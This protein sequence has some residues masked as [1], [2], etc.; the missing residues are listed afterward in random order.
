MIPISIGF[1]CETQFMIPVLVNEKKIKTIEGSTDTFIQYQLYSK[2]NDNLY[3]YG[4]AF[5]MTTDFAASR[6]FQLAR[7]TKEIHVKELYS[8][9]GDQPLQVKSF[10]KILK[11]AE[12]INTF[13]D[14]EPVQITKLWNHILKYMNKTINNIESFLDHPIKKFR[15]TFP[16]PFAYTHLYHYTTSDLV[17]ENLQRLKEKII[18]N[19]QDNKKLYT[20]NISRIETMYQDTHSI[21]EKQI[22]IHDSVYANKNKYQIG[23][24]SRMPFNEI[25]KKARFVFQ[26]TLGFPIVHSIQIMTELYKIVKKNTNDELESLD[27]FESA[28]NILARFEKH[29]KGPRRELYLNY[30]F[31][32]YYSSIT[33]DKRKENSLFSIRANFQ[34]LMYLLTLREKWMLYDLIHEPTIRA[35]FQDIHFSRPYL[36]KYD[37]MLRQ[38]NEYITAVIDPSLKRFQYSDVENDETADIMTKIY[39]EFRLLNYVLEKKLKTTNVTFNDIKT[40]R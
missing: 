4:D 9:Q 35:L 23:L 24:I 27:D 18:K 30:I 22:V 6:S 13:P 26:C 19:H 5:T 15:I 20:Q 25:S 12:F 10:N 33:I 21:L 8:R 16:T 17:S 40:M 1:E 37:A 38:K 32:F 14:N 3:I 28:L 7:Q 31:L 29:L 36:T 11:N 39:V 34:T 2:E